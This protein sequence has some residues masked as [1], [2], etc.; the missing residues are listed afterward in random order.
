VNQ[1]AR[2][3]HSPASEPTHFGSGWISGVLSTTFG[4]IGLAA[5]FCFHYPSLLTMPSLRSLYPLPYIR[6]L[7][8]LI[9][10]S[11]F[12]LGVL[13]VCLRR[14]K[15]LGLVGITLTLIAALLG[16]SRVPIEGELTQGPFLGLDWFLLNLIIYSVVFIPLERLFARLPDQPIFRRGWRT[17]LAYFFVSALLI[18]VTTILTLKPAMVFFHW[19]A[20]PGLQARIAAQP[21]ALQFLGILVLTDL[22]QYWVHRLFHTVPVL[23]R[24]HSIH[25]SAEALDWLAGSRLH[26]VDVAVTRGLTYIPIY[27]LGFWEAPLF[28]YVVFVSVQATFIHANIRFEFGPLRWLLTTPRFHHWHHAAEREAINKNFAVH[29]P[30]LD[31]LFGTFYFPGDRWPASYG[32]GRD[33][34]VPE[35]YARQFVYPFVGERSV[36]PRK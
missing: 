27:L 8:H 33:N 29:L 16:G 15:T 28:A 20:H 30:V 11:S 26:L 12:L 7:L 10:V 19:A 2:S 13:S 35:G 23:W 24:F 34:P 6:A 32:L 4:V 21:F 5:V 9:L 36:E 1:S 3:S 14:S 18:Q 22:T 25:H 17:D 31:W